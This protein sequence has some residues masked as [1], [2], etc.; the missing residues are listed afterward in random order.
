MDLNLVTLT[1]ATDDDRDFSYQVKRA[2]EGD[3][4]AAIWGWDDEVQRAFHARAWE[5]RHPDVI[6]YNGQRIGTL[7]AREEED[8]LHIRQFFIL[9]EWQSK[10]I[11]SFLLRRILTKADRKGLVAKC[12]FLKGNRVKS[13]YKRFG[14]HLTLQR[15]NYCFME[16]KPQEST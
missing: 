10:G 1:S 4:I 3:Y 5:G 6:R 12:A 9:P 2:A 16:R 7:F 11:G 14:F 13:L 15:D 8:G